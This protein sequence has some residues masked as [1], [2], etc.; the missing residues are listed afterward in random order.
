M[1]LPDIINKLDTLKDDEEQ[2]EKLKRHQIIE[3][4]VEREAFMTEFQIR[5]KSGELQTLFEHQYFKV[6]DAEEYF[7]YV[8][9]AL[10]FVLYSGKEESFDT[11]VQILFHQMSDEQ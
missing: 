2:A 1:P 6:K 11:K 9:L 3:R 7:D 4:V 5:E 8:K 10:F